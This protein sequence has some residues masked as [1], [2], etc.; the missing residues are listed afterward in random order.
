[1]ASVKALVGVD[2]LAHVLSSTIQNYKRQLTKLAPCPYFSIIKV[3]LADME[4]FEKSDEFQS[5]PFQDIKE[6]PKHHGR[7]DNVKTE[8]PQTNIVCGGIII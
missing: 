3:H 2:F 4:V 7:M 6:K 1:M 8:Y 5:L